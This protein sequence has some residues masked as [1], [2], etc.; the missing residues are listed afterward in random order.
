MRIGLYFGLVFVG[1]VGVKMF[2]YCFF[3][4]NVILVNKFEFCSVLRKINVSLIIY[5]YGLY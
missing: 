2:R 4:N 1:V 5:R 3:G